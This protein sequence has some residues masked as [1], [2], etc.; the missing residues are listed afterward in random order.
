VE[1]DMEMRRKMVA[2]AGAPDVGNKTPMFSNG[3]TNSPKSHIYVD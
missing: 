1:I 2:K 3:S